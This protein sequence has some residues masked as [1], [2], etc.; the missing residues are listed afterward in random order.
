MSI[1]SKQKCHFPFLLIKFPKPNLIILLFFG[2]STLINAQQN[3]KTN[4]FILTGKVI[5]Q[6]TGLLVLSYIN[7]FDKYIKDSCKLKK[8]QFKFE[9]NIIEPT[10]ADLTGNV[11][12]RSVSENN[13]AEFYIEPTTMEGV[14]KVDQFKNIQLIGS[15]T[16]KE[17]ERYNSISADLNIYRTQLKKQLKLAPSSWS[18]KQKDSLEE[19]LK[20]KFIT[21]QLYQESKFI[22][23]NPSSYVS[24]YVLFQLIHTAS[25]DTSLIYYRLLSDDVKKS[26]NAR[27]AFKY[28]ELEEK[29]AIG[30]IVP[31]FTFTD[32]NSKKIHINSFRGNY[33]LIDLWASWCVPCREEHPFLKDAYEEFHKKGFEIIGVSIDQLH[34]KNDWLN[35]IQKDGLPWIQTCDFKFFGGEIAQLFN[36]IGK[37][38]PLSF[39][40]DPS[41]KIIAKDLRGVELSNLLNQLINNNSVPSLFN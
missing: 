3:V 26:Y 24:S 31:D 21:E 16:Q 13:Y 15:K 8:G 33:V 11:N 35:A 23:E 10:L 40:I 1:T 39:L 2:F 4:K 38:I 18:Q 25:I 28:I 22:K 34:Q 29:I 12:S 6:D 17:F 9:G 32:I 30:A 36:I 5:G 27:Q 7:S 41:G 20:S 19:V 14:F 37:G